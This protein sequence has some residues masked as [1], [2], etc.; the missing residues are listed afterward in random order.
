MFKNKNIF[1]A[2]QCKVETLLISV[3]KSVSFAGVALPISM[4]F[5]LNYASSILSHWVVHLYYPKTTAIE[6]DWSGGRLPKEPCVF[7]VTVNTSFELTVIHALHFEEPNP[8]AAG[9]NVHWNI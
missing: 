5:W 6:T 8:F 1:I 7:T 3:P 9:D 2:K 4:G